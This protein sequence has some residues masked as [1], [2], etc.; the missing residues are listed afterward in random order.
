MKAP[1]DHHCP[2]APPEHAPSHLRLGLALLEEDRPEEARLAL[3]GASPGDEGAESPTAV[4]LHH[5]ALACSSWLVGRWDSA[6]IEVRAGLAAAEAR[7]GT[8]RGAALAGVGVVVA[9]HRDDL[10]DARSLLSRVQ[11]QLVTEVDPCPLW[12]QGAEALLVEAEGRPEMALQVMADG[13]GRAG[14]VRHLSGY[15]LFGPELVRL[16]LRFGDRQRAAS[17]THEVEDRAR[18]LS[19]PGARSAALRCQGMLD[20]DPG[21]LLRAVAALRETPRPLELASACEE[22][23][24]SLQRA[25]RASLARSLFGQA[26]TVY[27]SLGATRDIARIDAALRPGDAP[28]ATPNHAQ[29]PSPGGATGRGAGARLSAR[30]LEVL[31]LLAAGVGTRA[32]AGR[33]FLSHNTVRNHAQNV[34]R[35]LNVHSR[36]EAVSVARRDGLL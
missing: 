28:L 2:S 35:K 3:Q 22:A 36:L 6:A 10:R 4:P 33:L 11:R 26:R 15:R 31:E 13:W 7:G 20:D 32:I 29:R 5:W 14:A 18:G 12:S 23:A 34:L 21:V 16:A 19:V 30:E 9:V 25:D 24:V 1:T 17:V 8:P 27:C